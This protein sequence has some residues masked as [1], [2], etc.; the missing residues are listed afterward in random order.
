[1]SNSRRLRAGGDPVP[2]LEP[3]MGRA[4]PG[5][6]VSLPCGCV[7]WRQLPDDGSGEPVFVMIACK[8]D[9]EYAIYAAEQSRRLDHPTEIREL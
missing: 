8:T 2:F 1:M 4:V 5:S 3:D 7:F 9:C 6:C